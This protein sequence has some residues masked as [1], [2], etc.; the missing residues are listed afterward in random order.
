[1]LGSLLADNVMVS[2]Y[3]GG[4]EYDHG[5][6]K[7]LKSRA[8]VSGIDT[9][10]G[11][12]TYLL[13]TSYK[14][15]NI[16]YKDSQSLSNLHQH[17][18]SLIYNKYDELHMLKIGL[19]YLN[20]N[21]DSSYKDLGSGSVIILGVA[22]Y[23][24]FD[25]DKLTYGLDAY[26]SIYLNAHNDV[27]TTT[28]QM[29]DVVQFTPYLSYSRNI[30]ESTRNDI[31]FKINYI[32]ATEYKDDAYFSFEIS[33]TF[34]YESFYTTLRYFGGDMKSGVI[35]G[36]LKVFNTKDLYR[37]SYQLRVGYYILADV[38]IDLSAGVND[39]KEYDAKNLVLLSSGI[40]T[41][42]YITLSC[43]F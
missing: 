15:I 37:N 33:D 36:G 24:W 10:L 39:Y 16:S 1:M 28:T 12:K 32:A 27:S 7:S 31:D 21:E 6:S 19:H 40:N 43:N 30:S 9:T 5:L 25:K 4:L 18:L 29:V 23:N 14:Y 41:E 35:D 26:Y 22:G 11:D 8:K 13:Q 34:V 3:V 38:A 17:E 20:N 42:G 2:P